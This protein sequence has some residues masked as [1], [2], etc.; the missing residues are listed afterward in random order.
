MIISGFREFYRGK[1]SVRVRK[2]S[3]AEQGIL[4]K[5]EFIIPFRF[6]VQFRES[7]GFVFPA[8]FVFSIAC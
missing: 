8:L 4:S 3:Y 1:S 2:L 5:Q 7:V 6:R